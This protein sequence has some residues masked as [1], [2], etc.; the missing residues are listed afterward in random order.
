MPNNCLC[1][2]DAL[3][4]RELRELIRS[5]FRGLL[6][7]AKAKHSAPAQAE[8]VDARRALAAMEAERETSVAQAQASLLNGRLPG[9]NHQG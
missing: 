8:L 7:S 5:R 4:E 1:P 3:D 9:G 2:Q 6:A